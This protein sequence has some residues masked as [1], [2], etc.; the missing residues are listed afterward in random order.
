MKSKS[1]SHPEVAWTIELIT[2]SVAEDAANAEDAADPARYRSVAPYSEYL[3]F[4]NYVTQIDAFPD[5]TFDIVLVDGRARPACLIHALPKVRRGGLLILD[6]AERPHY[7]Q[8]IRQVTD[9]DVLAIEEHVTPAC[10]T[11]NTTLVF[12]IKS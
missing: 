11:L 7:Q 2:P 9:A 8:A 5:S 6:N 12:T 4:Q 1:C 10:D 3:D